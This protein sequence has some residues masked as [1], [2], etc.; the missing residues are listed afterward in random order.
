[1]RC[2]A[3]ATEKACSAQSQVRLL[4]HFHGTNHNCVCVLLDSRTKVFI[5]AVYHFANLGLA[6]M[7]LL[8]TAVHC[9]QVAV[10][11][12]KLQLYLLQV[13]QALP[14]DDDQSQ[15]KV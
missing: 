13:A 4:L 10:H 3:P 11:A 14:K 9:T 12:I 7:C 15:L 8:R 6:C 1:M 2:C 5:T